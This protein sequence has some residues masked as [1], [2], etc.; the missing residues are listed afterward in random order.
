[1]QR[2]TC[3]VWGVERYETDFDAEVEGEVKGGAE[4]KVQVYNGGGMT[5]TV[6]V[7]PI[8]LH[9]DSEDEEEEDFG[10]DAS[11]CYS[12]EGAN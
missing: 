5:S 12:F 3:K 1:M 6:I 7:A 9:S 11:S 4:P 2:L 8:K 10:G